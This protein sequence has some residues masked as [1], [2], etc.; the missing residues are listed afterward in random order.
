MFVHAN[1]SRDI[2]LS[3]WPL[4]LHVHRHQAELVYTST[5]TGQPLRP[6]RRSAGRMML[7]VTVLLGV[8]AVCQARPD[9]LSDFAKRSDRRISGHDTRTYCGIGVEECARRCQTDTDYNCRSFEHDGSC[10]RTSESNTEND[11]GHYEVRSGTDYYELKPGAWLDYYTEFKNH[12][13]QDSA[14]QVLCNLKPDD[15]GRKCM[16]ATFQCSVHYGSYFFFFPVD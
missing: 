11:P 2:K 8:L 4:V 3:V 12:R 1:D 16:Q 6:C 7:C 5:E 9:A 14:S 13:L 10:C 15:C